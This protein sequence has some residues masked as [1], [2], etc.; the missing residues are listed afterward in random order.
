MCGVLPVLVVL[1]S[2]AEPWSPQ[3][4]R[5]A[6]MFPEGFR[7]DVRRSAPVAA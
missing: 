3:M 1:I 5:L 7:L 6:R 4:E 2:G